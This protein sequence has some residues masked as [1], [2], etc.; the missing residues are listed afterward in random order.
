MNNMFN[1]FLIL[2]LIFIAPVSIC[3][4]IATNIRIPKDVSECNAQYGYT[5]IKEIGYRNLVC[6]NPNNN[7]SYYYTK[8]STSRGSTENYTFYLNGNVCGS[9]CDFEG[10]NCIWGICNVSSCDKTHGYTELELEKTNSKN[11]LWLC[12]KKGTKLSYRPVNSK[13]AVNVFYYN[14]VECG[15]DCDMNGKNCVYEPGL[16]S[17]IGI[18]NPED[19]PKGYI[20]QQGYCKN[21]ATNELFYK[22][23]DGK[24][25]S[26]DV[27]SKKVDKDM[28][29]GL[30]Q[31]YNKKY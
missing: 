27:R 16:Y 26:D 31:L 2:L 13:I 22:D 11:K 30:K 18:C 9:D 19:C 3:Y 10:K 5:Q 14:G 24:F 28:K 6:H 21:P 17:K 23:K 12:R 1:K 29:N 7:M 20:I 15:S 4:A 25:K 8:F